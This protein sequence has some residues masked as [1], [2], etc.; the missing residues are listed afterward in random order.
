MGPTIGITGKTPC[1]PKDQ[2]DPGP[3]DPIYFNII[4]L[5]LKKNYKQFIYLILRS[6]Y[7]SNPLGKAPVFP[8]VRRQILDF[9]M[10]FILI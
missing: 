5:F 3:P 2:T 1:I 4:P 7:G 10:H 8:R 9:R 6:I